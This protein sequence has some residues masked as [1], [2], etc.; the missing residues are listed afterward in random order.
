MPTMPTM[1]TT[2][3]KARHGIILAVAHSDLPPLALCRQLVT[4]HKHGVQ[5]VAVRTCMMHGAPCILLAANELGYA[6]SAGA[7]F[8][9]MNSR[10][11]ARLARVRTALSL[12]RSA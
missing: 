4:L 3:R 5:H 11:L 6:V 8:D 2:T 9:T 10:A 1:P 7:Q 12:M